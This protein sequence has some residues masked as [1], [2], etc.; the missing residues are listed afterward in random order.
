M[1]SP[2]P[3]PLAPTEANGQPAL[4]IVMLVAFTVVAASVAVALFRAR[5]VL[6]KMTA[7]AWVA[8]V[9]PFVGIV[10]SAIGI[11]VSAIAFVSVAVLGVWLVAVL[12]VVSGKFIDPLTVKQVLYVYGGWTRFDLQEEQGP[13]LVKTALPFAD[14]QLPA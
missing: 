10:L 4:S 13:V 14:M 2:P 9:A 11:S 1:S 8:M 5:Q 12:I 7:G 3:P 6:S